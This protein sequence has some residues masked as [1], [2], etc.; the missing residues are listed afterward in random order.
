MVLLAVVSVPISFIN[1]LNKFAV[2]TLLSKANYLQAFET[3][4]LQAQVLL[5]LDL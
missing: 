3:D 2:L 5:Y 1:M 4:T